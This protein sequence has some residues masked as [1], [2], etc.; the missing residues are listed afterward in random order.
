MASRRPR[1]QLA[2]L[3][4]VLFA[5][6]DDAQAPA[7]LR[8]AFVTIVPVATT[9]APG[10]TLTLS[11]FPRDSTGQSVGVRPVSWTTSSL[12][13]V[14]ID[15]TGL[16]R[17]IGPG[18]ATI[19]ATIDGVPGEAT[20]VVMAPLITMPFVSVSAGGHHTC[21]IG[22]PSVVLC[23]GRN[24]DGQIGDGT[25]VTPVQPTTVPIDGSIVEV[26]TGARH[27]CALGETG[28]V[29][30][31]GWNA[32]GQAGT[33]VGQDKRLTEPT[34]IDAAGP[35]TMLAAGNAHNC[36]LTL[37]ASATCWGSNE[38]SQLGNASAGGGT[39]TITTPGPFVD[40]DA[41]HAH[42]CAVTAS[43]EIWCWGWNAFQQLGANAVITQCAQNVPCS[44]QPQRLTGLPR[45]ISVRAGFAFTCALAVDNGTWCWGLGVDGQLGTGARTTSTVPIAVAGGHRFLAIDAGAAHACGITE[46]GEAWCWGSNRSGQLGDGTRVDRE[47]PVRVTIVD[48]PITRLSAGEAH[49]CAVFDDGRIGCWGSAGDGRLGPFAR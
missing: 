13:V 23:W 46:S 34:P 7:L 4:P 30:C 16:A 2:A 40:I 49:T 35:F 5:C 1:F 45:V 48:R 32:S 24:K 21:A 22:S 27:T 33:H 12:D 6:A 10:D 15:S 11:A 31:W 19:T 37:A 17:A 9:L 43:G 18:T 25:F 41:G 29:V 44:P 20:I 8:I 3:V 26:V 39:T 36:A 47:V 14:R 42:T 28:N 38:I